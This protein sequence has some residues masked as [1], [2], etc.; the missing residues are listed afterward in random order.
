MHI[1]YSF[2][3]LWPFAL[4]LLV[5]GVC[6]GIMAG[7]LGV[8]GGIVIVPV[9]YHVFTALG[10]DEGVRMHLAVATSLGVIIPTSIRSVRAHA[11]RGAVDFKLLR[12]WAPAVFIGT[13][14]GT[15]I[16]DFVSGPI[17]TG[18]FATVALVVSA[19]YAFSRAE[20]R[21]G[22]ALP[23][24]FPAHALAGAIGCLSALM[25]IGGGTFAVTTMTLYGYPIHRAVGTAAGLGLIISVPGTIGHIIGGWHHAN[26][27]PLSL[28][29]VNLLGFALITPTTVLTAPW[30]VTLAH[31]L[32]RKRLIQA[33][34]LFLAVT[35][36]KMYWGLINP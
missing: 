13:L 36:I 9:L 14:I 33:F 23:T 2:A 34:A 16:A 18:I 1:D 35:S 12:S 11:K 5:A 26:L 27:P 10:I 24:G 6:A 31:A 30:G 29:Y 4:G 3:A 25:G 22:E 7:L 20:W 21:L 28:G 19:N 15:M 32:P 17:L 8:G